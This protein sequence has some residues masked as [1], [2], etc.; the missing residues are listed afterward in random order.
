MLI[1]VGVSYVS[2]AQACANAEQEIPN[3]EFDKVVDQSKAL[4]NEKS[5]QDRVTLFVHA[6]LSAYQMLSFSLPRLNRVHIAND[7]DPK[8]AQLFYT[9]LYR[10]FL[11][12]NNATLEG[13]AQFLNTASPYF[14]GLYCKALG[15]F[16]EFEKRID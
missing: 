9:S 2:P 13:Q 4:W 14:D 11:S 15:R 5:V 7:T 16:Q 12:P 6:I 8:I 10:S 3:F 1:R